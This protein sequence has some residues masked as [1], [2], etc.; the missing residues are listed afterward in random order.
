M[1]SIKEKESQFENIELMKLNRTIERYARCSTQL[2]PP[3]L[4]RTKVKT[5]M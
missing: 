4:V 3:R 1:L 2:K 5:I